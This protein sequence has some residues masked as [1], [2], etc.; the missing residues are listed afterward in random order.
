MEWHGDLYLGSS[1]RHR[2][3]TIKWKIMHHAGQ[4]RVYVI[5][6]ASN[7][8]NLLDIIP[9]WELM[10]KHYPKRG[11]Y[12]VGLAGSY[13]EALELAGQI[14]NEVYRATGS[15]DVR[16]YIRQHGKQGT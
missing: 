4:L 15:F 13:N 11:L 16:S 6:L 14:I 7:E 1:V 5:T 3:R 2:K 8:R 10:Q 12:A 9:S